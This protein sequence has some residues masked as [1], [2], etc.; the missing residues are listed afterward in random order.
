MNKKNNCPFESAQI[1][2]VE[3]LVCDII[4]ASPTG[5]DPFPGEDDD[6]TTT[7]YWKN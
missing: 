2:I 3:I 1:E 7:Y 6:L 4:T 5:P